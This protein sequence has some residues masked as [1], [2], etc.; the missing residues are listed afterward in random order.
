VSE[1]WNFST[2]V[3]GEDPPTFDKIHNNLGEPALC[4]WDTFNYDEEG[5]S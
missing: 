2:F 1:L 3:Y 4:V 5:V